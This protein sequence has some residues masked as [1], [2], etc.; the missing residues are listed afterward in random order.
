LSEISNSVYQVCLYFACNE[1]A[2]AAMGEKLPKMTIKTITNT[3]VGGRLGDRNKNASKGL[4]NTLDSVHPERFARPDFTKWAV[5]KSDPS[6]KPD[7]GTVVDVNE[8]QLVAI[9]GTSTAGSVR[10]ESVSAPSS[11]TRAS[12]VLVP[13]AV[14]VFLSKLP[15]VSEY[16]GPNIDVD[17]MIKIIMGLPVQVPTGNLT[18][19]P[20]DEYVTVP[21]QRYDDRRRGGDDRRDRREREYRDRR[22]PYPTSSRSDPR[23][24]PRR[25]GGGR[26]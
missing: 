24:D 26:R 18:W 25:S 11:P 6:I 1:K 17:E 15:H 19:I 2:L 13:P 3:R 5:F 10:E 9:K 12:G 16:N 20:V 23:S 7:V 8:A 21:S 4:A 14:A 22:E